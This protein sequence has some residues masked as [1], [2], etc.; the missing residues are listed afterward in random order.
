[1]APRIRADRSDETVRLVFCA[2]CEEPACLPACPEG[3]LVP[4]GGVVAVDAAK[5][6]S[7]P[8]CLEAC[9]FGAIRVTPGTAA[10]KCDLC[11]TRPGGPA[12]VEACP[13][14]A[15]ARVEPERD[16][17]KKNLAA[18]LAR[19]AIRAGRQAA[20]AGSLPAAGNT[21]DRTHKQAGKL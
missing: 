7:C 20:G 8:R 14:N 19:L 13:E 5:C 4:K 15:L 12:C 6:R 18:A 17:K 10:R 1:M 3:A 11:L 21:D 16:R 9:P 2:H